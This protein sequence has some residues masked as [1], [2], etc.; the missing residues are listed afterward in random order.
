MK[1]RYI[2]PF[3]FL[4]IEAVFSQP[5]NKE[6]T[7]IKNKSF[8][9]GENKNYFFSQ[10]TCYLSDGK[11]YLEIFYDFN[12]DGKRDVACYFPIVLLRK[13][14]TKAEIK[15]QARVHLEDFDCD[16]IPDF[17]YKDTNGNGTLD[18]NRK[19]ERK[20]KGDEGD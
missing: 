15:D 19:L 13:D 8:S 16:D 7:G 2:L 4:G 3:L 11:P 12:K 18:K 17:Y 6:G 5:Q 9:R 20:V 1:F 10:D 14:S